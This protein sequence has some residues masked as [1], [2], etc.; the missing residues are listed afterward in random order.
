MDKETKE[1]TD[2]IEIDFLKG[3]CKLINTHFENGHNLHSDQYYFAKKYLQNTENCDKIAKVFSRKL[4]NFDFEESTTFI[5]LHNYTGLVLDKSLQLIDTSYNYEIINQENKKFEWQTVPSLKRNL[6]IVLP[7]SCTFSLHAR[8]KNFIQ[9][10]IN[11]NKERDESQLNES[12]INEKFIV[13]FIVLDTFLKDRDSEEILI[14]QLE[15]SSTKSKSHIFEIYSL[16]NWTEIN[17]T[18][19]KIVNNNSEEFIAYPLIKLY[20]NLRLPEKCDKCFPDEKSNEILDEMPL[21]TTNYDFDSPNLILGLPKFNMIPNKKQFNYFETFNAIDE[22]RSLLLYGNIAANN[23]RYL[24]YIRGNDFFLKNKHEIIT[25]FDQELSDKYGKDFLVKDHK[26][27]NTSEKILDFFF[28]TP[29]YSHNSKFLE[30]LCS[31]PF[32]RNK[33]TT[34][35]RFQSD[36]ES[37]DNFI[38]LYCSSLKEKQ[39]ENTKIIFFQEVLLASRDFK[40]ISDYLK[41]YRTAKEFIGNHGFDLIFTLVDRTNLNTRNEIK[42]KL[43]WRGLKISPGSSIETELEN[44]IISFYKLNLPDIDASHLGNPLK[45]KVADLKLMLN[46]THLDSIKET[47]LK[48]I[49]KRES[50]NLPEITQKDWKIKKYTYFPFINQLGTFDEG[51]YE[52]YKNSITPNKSNLLYTF[53]A[54]EI[55]SELSAPKYNTS[56]YDKNPPRKLVDEII[57]LILNRISHDMEKFFCPNGKYKSRFRDKKMETEL[58]REIVVK[59]LSRHPSIYYKD[60]YDSMFD[61]CLNRFYSLFIEIENRSV[62][63]FKKL[64]RLKFYLRRLVQLNSNFIISKRFL[65]FIKKVYEE[66]KIGKVIE[67]YKKKILDNKNPSENKLFYE[68]QLYNLNYILDQIGSLFRSFLFYY[69]ELIY[70]NSAKS[71]KLEHLMNLK[72]LLPSLEEHSSGEDIRPL[73]K[74]KY[75]HFINMLQSENVYLLTELKNY[76]IEKIKNENINILSEDF[77][78][79]ENYKEYYFSNQSFTNTVLINAKKLIDQYSSSLISVEEIIGA[80]CQMLHTVTVLTKKNN[81]AGISSQ[82][83]KNFNTEIKEILQSLVNIIKY[84]MPK[85]SFKYAF[86]MKHKKAAGINEDVKNIYTILENESEEYPEITTLNSK[87]VIFNLLNG[88]YE[89]LETGNQQSLITALKT[90]D[91]GVI[92]FSDYYH[93]NEPINRSEESD[94]SFKNNKG[95]TFTEMFNADLH[96]EKNGRKLNQMLKNA[97]MSLYIR[98][99]TNIY[100]ENKVRKDKIKDQDTYLEGAAVLLITTTEKSTKENFLK[101]IHIEKLRLI[102]LLKEEILHYL[103]RQVDNNAFNEVLENREKTLLTQHLKHGLGKYI[104]QQYLLVHDILKKD[105]EHKNYD[106]FC[107]I[108]EALGGQLSASNVEPTKSEE[109]TYDVI[110][111]RIKLIFESRIDG[112]GISFVNVNI[113]K[114][115][116]KKITLH[117]LLFTTVLTELIINM[118]R[119]GPT[120]PGKNDYIL[121]YENNLE[122]KEEKLIFKNRIDKTDLEKSGQ[123][124]ILCKELLRKMHYKDIKET[125]ENS[126]DKNYYVITLTLNKNDTN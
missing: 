50:K 97:Q 55:N 86:F 14:K 10:F 80:V 112:K 115:K 9:D 64:W 93:T 19:I 102:L 6:V 13:I 61:Y 47:I 41:H 111:K 76:H 66:D 45:K 113:D 63:P 56:V 101:F 29:E 90:E 28:V 103:Q 94:F 122:R 37:V 42:K 17:K 117:P 15:N 46:E 92:S 4:L 110:I 70:K 107:I 54:N 75:F 100:E 87:G 8:L 18:Q 79:I 60:I 3:G 106:T 43:Y 71:I 121:E 58:V 7:I 36:Y 57:E 5:G 119:H 95:M 35:V 96:N 2:E 20:S 69:K 84:G 81:S 51:T 120:E 16:F 82:S 104:D 34:I 78:N 1:I 126:S 40:L 32:L 118:K 73:I 38:S 99:S 124:K 77:N 74:N 89:D 62:I 26:K 72:E 25:F 53:I 27:K 59:I 105:N 83:R 39:N 24:D 108:T 22:S 116:F 30:H 109:Y 85:D 123:G 33:N 23:G 68:A 11:K 98:F 49:I 48:K 67:E 12:R 114:I 44:R 31:A 21:F 52:F 125:Y 88:I 65:K 91:E